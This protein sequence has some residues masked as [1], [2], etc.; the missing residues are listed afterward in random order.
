MSIAAAAAYAAAQ[1]AAKDVTESR[2]K[3]NIGLSSFDGET[4]LQYESPNIQILQD[5]MLNHPVGKG[6]GHGQV[7]MET[8][9]MLNYSENDEIPV[10][11]RESQQNKCATALDMN[12]FPNTSD[13]NA[14]I[15]GMVRAKQQTPQ[16]GLQTP[17]DTDGATAEA[18]MNRP[19]ENFITIAKDGTD[20]VLQYVV[21]NILI[22]EYLMIFM[23]RLDGCLRFLTLT[24]IHHYLVM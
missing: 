14:V 6:L 21:N 13:A 12:P 23:H 9:Q 16:N 2:K 17:F 8:S 7:I 15:Q 20:L 3:D 11:M 19:K 22:L 5:E 4:D 10:N 18:M 1:A 24:E